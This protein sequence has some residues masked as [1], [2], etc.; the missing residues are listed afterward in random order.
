MSQKIITVHSVQQKYV[1]YFENI[2]HL[3]PLHD[4]IT[5]SVFDIFI[6]EDEMNTKW[7]W[8]VES[9]FSIIYWFDVSLITKLLHAVSV[10]INLTCT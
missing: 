5:E 3:S 10:P 4:R 8:P 6:L 7:K 2:I 1:H 9:Y